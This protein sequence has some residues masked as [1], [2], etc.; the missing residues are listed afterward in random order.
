MS[1]A[2]R[3]TPCS[4]IRSS[5]A[6]TSP[7]FLFS[8]FSSLVMQAVRISPAPAAAESVIKCLRSV[9]I[10]PPLILFVARQ[11]LRS[12]LPH[13]EFR[14]FRVPLSDRLQRDFRILRPIR[15]RVYPSLRLASHQ[16]MWPYHL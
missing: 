5:V 1:K 3:R 14:R 8:F 10:V 7:P 2:R 11:A 13:R 6:V 15:C 9:S 12:L 4:R 16:P